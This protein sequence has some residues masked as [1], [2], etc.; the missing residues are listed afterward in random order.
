MSTVVFLI[1]FNNVLCFNESCNDV[2]TATITNKRYR[3]HLTFRKASKFFVSIY[4]S[5]S[6]FFS[7]LK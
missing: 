7:K 6:T 1:I 4:T 3:R 2:T 5:V